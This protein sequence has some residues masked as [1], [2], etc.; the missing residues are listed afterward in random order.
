VSEGSVAVRHACVEGPNE[1]RYLEGAIA[2]ECRRKGEE[3]VGAGLEGC[4]GEGDPSGGP[5]PVVSDTND[6]TRGCRSEAR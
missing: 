2:G 4:E 6:T 3:E 5:C 1:D